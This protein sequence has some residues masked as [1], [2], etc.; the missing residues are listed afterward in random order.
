MQIAPE[1]FASRR[2]TLAF[3][4]CIVLS[5]A[6]R[7]APVEVQQAVASGITGTVL[8]PFLAI[9]EQVELMKG[10]GA[11]V[12]QMAA[13]HDSI[14]AIALESVAL[15]EENERLR[16]LLDL[17]ARMTVQHVSAEVLPQSLPTDGMTLRISVGRSHGVKVM[18][19]VIAPG[20]IVGVIRQSGP[21]TSVV[22]AWTHP[23]FRASA[24]T[25]DGTIFGIAAQRG[26]EGPYATLIELRGVPFRQDVPMGSLVY[27]SGRGVGLGGV[28]P[29][30]IKIGTVMAVGEEGREGWSSTYVVRPAVH[31]ASLSHVIVLTGTVGDVSHVFEDV[32]Q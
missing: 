13:A 10:A 14:S 8:A 31:P 22:L 7:V 21:S 18:D 4:I 25:G 5:L 17:S 26:S 32:G 24:M 12:T 19:P 29:R 15:R 9:Q 28:Y 6:A 16:E 20:G 27:T 3:L 23:D 30:G 11:R 1:R 2:D